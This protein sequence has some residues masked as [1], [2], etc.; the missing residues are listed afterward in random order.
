MNTGFGGGLQMGAIN[1]IFTYVPT[2]TLPT[3]SPTST[4]TRPNNMTTQKTVTDILTAVEGIEENHEKLVRT[5]G[6]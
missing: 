6:L 2:R 4:R 5:T 1:L 3:S